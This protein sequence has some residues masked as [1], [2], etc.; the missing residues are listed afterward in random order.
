M[1]LPTAEGSRSHVHLTLETRAPPEAIWALWTGV[2]SWPR[3]NTEVQE[4]TLEAPIAFDVQGTLT[5]KAGSASRFRI[6]AWEPS[7]RY[8]FTTAL[9]GGQL[10]VTRSLEVVAGV[11]RFTHDVAYTGAMG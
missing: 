6:S 9:P 5:P 1:A 11:T 4:V 8:A 2:A 10:T 7:R 3:W